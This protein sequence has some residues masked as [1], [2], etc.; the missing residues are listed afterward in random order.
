MVTVMGTSSFS[1]A[2]RRLATSLSFVAYIMARQITS[3]QTW[4][5]RR[6]R[7]WI[8]YISDVSNAEIRSSPPPLEMLH[9]L[10][11]SISQAAC[12][13]VSPSVLRG[14]S[15]DRVQLVYACFVVR[16]ATLWFNSWVIL[17]LTVTQDAHSHTEP[18]DITYTSHLRPEGF[19]HILE[20]I[21]IILGQSASS[22]R[23]L[24]TPDPCPA[25][26]VEM[27][28]RRPMELVHME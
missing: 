17:I 25:H 5:K 9:S 22:L 14:S 12:A 4:P 15:V 28:K 6:V 7:T 20:I 1:P 8:S 19:G 3:D 11:L 27:G 23:V 18:G 10:Y 21:Q 24:E 16:S 2:A 26:F 13:S